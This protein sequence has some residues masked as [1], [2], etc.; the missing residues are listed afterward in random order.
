MAAQV[1]GTENVTLPPGVGPNIVHMKQHIQPTHGHDWTQE[2]VWEI[3]N[4]GLRINTIA[5]TGMF[6]YHIKD[7]L[8]N[9][10]SNN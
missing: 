9:E 3:T 2:L 6:H 8:K 4:P 7:W 10:P 1:I 5:Q